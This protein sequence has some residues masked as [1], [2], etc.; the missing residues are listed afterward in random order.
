[1]NYKKLTF[2]LVAELPVFSMLFIMIGF[3]EFS[4]EVLSI[5]ITAKG[6]TTSEVLSSDIQILFI[7]FLSIIGAFLIIVSAYEFVK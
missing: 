1:M 6:V 3:E 4:A 2:E 7:V 5:S